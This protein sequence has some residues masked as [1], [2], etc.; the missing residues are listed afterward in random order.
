MTYAT[1]ETTPCL[2]ETRSQDQSRIVYGPVQSRRLG[3]SLGVDL[4]PAEEKACNFDCLYCECGWTP[5]MK[6]QR[7]WFPSLDTLMR[8]LAR[9]LPVL[10]RLHPSIDTITFSGRGEPTMFPEFPAAVSLV[11][12]LGKR[13][14][15]WARLAILTNGTMLG[16]KS[17]F[18]AVCRLDV[19]CVK[20]DA[21][22]AWMNRP[23]Q[24]IS[25]AD[26]LPVW[27][28]VPNLTI[29]SF[30][31]EGRFD[32]THREWVDPWIEQVKKVKPRRVQLYT[33]DRKPAAAGMQKASL[34]T[35]NRIGR[36]LSAETVAEV[37][38]FE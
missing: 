17:L 26:L 8:T 19:R 30:F 24:G 31:G 38:I 22:A 5:W 13:Y 27:A 4:L 37:C 35:L 12:E 25:V 1:A 20:L 16:A 7:T 6:P 21:G 23:R 18:D 29:Q 11:R 9:R 34:S 2:R 15:P 10:A 3:F 32:N 33:L 36:R 28:A 14:L